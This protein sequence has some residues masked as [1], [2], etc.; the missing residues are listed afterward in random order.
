MRRDF[1]PPRLQGGG[2][3][4]YPS[5]CKEIM[6]YFKSDGTPY[7]FNKIEYEW[8]EKA[9]GKILKFAED[10]RSGKISLEDCQTESTTLGIDED[11]DRYRVHKRFK[12]WWRK[13]V[14][15]KSLKKF[16]EDH[17]RDY[18]NFLEKSGVP[19][20]FGK[21]REALQLLGY[22]NKDKRRA[23]VEDGSNFTRYKKSSHSGSKSNRDRHLHGSHF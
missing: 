6:N 11:Q 17:F 21:N 10:L 16:F 5:L 13:Y 23:I 20:I 7:D 15:E 4:P 22:D 1:F 2:I 3:E 12:C 9:K 19:S 18:R 14:S 8:L